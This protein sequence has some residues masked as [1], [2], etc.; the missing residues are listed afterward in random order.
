MDTN[1]TTIDEF[2]STY[3]KDTQV[4]LNKV[5]E[6]IRK[7]VPEA[8]EKISY[9]IPTFTFHGNLVHFSAYD[10]HIG[11]YPGSAPI[12]EFAKELEPYKTAKG[13]IRFPLDR[14]IP[15]EL[16]DKITRYCVVRNL[17]RKKK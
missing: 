8:G 13:T 5:R 4:K 2:I 15:Y 14:P 1:V 12:V 6:T 16:I 17:E 9:G 10:K 11:F 3:P 7:A